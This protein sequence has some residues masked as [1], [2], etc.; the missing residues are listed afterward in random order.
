MNKNN[1]LNNFERMRCYHK[2]NA[3]LGVCGEKAKAEK[4]ECLTIINQDAEKIKYRDKG[5]GKRFLNKQTDFW[6]AVIFPKEV[7]Q[8]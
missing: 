7:V 8:Q 6:R 1:E 2:S 4:K 3:R 5:K